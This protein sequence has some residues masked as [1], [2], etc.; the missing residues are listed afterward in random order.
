MDDMRSA[1]T[2]EEVPIEAPELEAMEGDEEG[3]PISDKAARLLR[4]FWKRRK[5]IVAIAAGGFVLTVL[6]AFTR[7]YVYLSTTSLM[8]PDNSSPYGN[9]LSLM[10]GSSSA[11][12]LASEALGLN[13]PGELF[14]AILESRNVQDGLISRFNLIHEYH[15]KDI[16]GARKALASSSTIHEDVKSGIIS[17]STTAHTPQLAAQLAAGYVQELNR[18]MTTDS[19]SSA[20]RERIFLE[21]RLSDI[22]K[23]LD[24]SSLALSQFSTKSKTFDIAD[25]GRSMLEEGSRL[26]AELI[27]GRSQLAAL[28]QTYSEDN[29]MVKA[30]QARV[31][32]LQ[33][34]INVMGGTSGGND[35]ADTGSSIYPPV[36]ALPRLGLTYYDLERRVKVDEA[37]WEALTKEYEMA[38]VEEAKEIPT[39][40]VLDAADIPLRRIAPRHMVIVA[41]GTLL[42]LIL[43]LIYAVGSNGWDKMDEQQEP[44]KLL[45]EIADSVR[46]R[47]ANRRLRRLS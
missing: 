26:E 9:M 21:G 2:V 12:G 36:S 35:A 16:V 5:T 14:I 31:A 33:R 7:P 38:R 10:S 18:V 40:R 28:Q 42:S 8:P 3:E 37:L 22:K 46:Q 47:R 32:E 20:R 30:A 1:T 19:T 13:S 11:A 41:L 23:D 34:E 44:K 25:Q 15:A 43:A 24:D 29:V 27:E 39:V 6:F 4:L 45:R 17:I